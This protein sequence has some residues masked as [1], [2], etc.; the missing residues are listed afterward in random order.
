M[1]PD[2]HRTWICLKDAEYMVTVRGATKA[3]LRPERRI[4]VYIYIVCFYCPS[5]KKINIFD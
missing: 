1:N 5:I 2:I 4:M 3:V